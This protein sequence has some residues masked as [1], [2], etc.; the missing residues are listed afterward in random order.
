MQDG[1]VLFDALTFGSVFVPTE[2]VYVSIPQASMLDIQ[3]I[4]EVVI[5]DIRK[6]FDEATGGRFFGWRQ[7]GRADLVR[8]LVTGVVATSSTGRKVDLRR[9]VFKNAQC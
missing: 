3:I 7:S 5:L 9:L 8:H 4:V 1:N 6:D 2:V